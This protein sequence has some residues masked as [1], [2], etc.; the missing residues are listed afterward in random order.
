MRALRDITPLV[1]IR[2]IAQQVSTLPL[3]AQNLK[4]YLP[5][6]PVMGRSLAQVDSLDRDRKLIE[7]R[8]IFTVPNR[9]A[10][11]VDRTG[12]PKEEAAD[13]LRVHGVD[14]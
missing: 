5:W 2:R 1:R 7:G 11:S 10:C 13:R 12:Y 3:L 4:E 9:T 14:V 6:I 8:L